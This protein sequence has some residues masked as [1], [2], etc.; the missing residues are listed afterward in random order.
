MCRDISI[1]TTYLNVWTLFYTYLIS[2]MTWE[3]LAAER[4][5]ASVED[6]LAW[7]IV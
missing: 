2:F 7:W 4:F 5:R 3:V 1:C 6:E